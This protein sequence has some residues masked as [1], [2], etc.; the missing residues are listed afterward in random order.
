MPRIHFKRTLSAWV[1]LSI[2][3][4]IF[5]VSCSLESNLATEEIIKKSTAEMAVLFVQ[6]VGLG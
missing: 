4:L 2:M 1:Y 3:T 6:M 5:A